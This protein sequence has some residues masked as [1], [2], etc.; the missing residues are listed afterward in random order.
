MTR[1]WASGSNPD[2]RPAQ[3]P[4]ATSTRVAIAPPWRFPEPL[5]AG[6]AT[7]ISMTT[8]PSV[9][10]GSAKRRPSSA[11]SGVW[12][13]AGAEQRVRVG[14]RRSGFVGH[15]RTVAAGTSAPSRT[16]VRRGPVDRELGHGGVGRRAA[17]HAVVAGAPR[18]RRR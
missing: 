4:A 5:K 2:T 9:G 14:T 8:V 10:S 6:G 18:R 12:V 16:S 1:L 11:W 13:N 7:S 17:P 3:D 15:Q